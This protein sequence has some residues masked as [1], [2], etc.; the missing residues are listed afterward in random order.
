M[1]AKRQVTEDFAVEH[2]AVLGGLL[3][4]REELLA[5]STGSRRSTGRR[6]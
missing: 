5:T 1:A 4:E 6:G 3:R 2:S